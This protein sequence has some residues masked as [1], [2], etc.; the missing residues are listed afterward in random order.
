MTRNPDN[1]VETVVPVEDPALRAEL[2]IVLDA[3]RSDDRKCWKMHA[4]GSYHQRRPDGDAPQNAHRRL[5]DRAR[6][7]YDR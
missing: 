2:Q 3:L 5:M 7:N 6:Q 1:R 4:D